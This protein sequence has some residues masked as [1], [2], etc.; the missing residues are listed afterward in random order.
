M[1][2]A[3]MHIKHYVYFIPTFFFI[4]CQ[5]TL[6]YPDFLS[7]WGL[8]WVLFPVKCFPCH[9]DCPSLHLCLIVHFFL[10]A[11]FPPFVTGSSCQLC[12]YLVFVHSF[13]HSYVH[14]FKVCRFIPHE[15]MRDR[16]GRFSADVWQNSDI[17]PYFTEGTASRV[18]C[19]YSPA[20]LTP[21]TTSSATKCSSQGIGLKQNPFSG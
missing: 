20:M 21:L 3:F 6:S 15:G 11:S 2:D 8:M 19:R 9:S 18:T 12:K 14:I 5:D 13:I 1:C 10:A 7:Y 17:F 16:E 4:L